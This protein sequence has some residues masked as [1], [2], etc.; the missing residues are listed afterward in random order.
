MESIVSPSTTTPEPPVFIVRP[1]CA[2]SFSIA[3]T[4]NGISGKISRSVWTVVVI[5]QE[6]KEN[7]FLG[8]I[9]SVQIDPTAVT[10]DLPSC[11]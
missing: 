5:R 9:K 7:V 4:V 3:S 11:L 8:A 10:G 1:F 6:V 2:N